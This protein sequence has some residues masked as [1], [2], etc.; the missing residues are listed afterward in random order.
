MGC[1]SD[2]RKD[3]PR[4]QWASAGDIARLRLLAADSTPSWQETDVEAPQRPDAKPLYLYGA[5]E[6]PAVR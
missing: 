1:R 2:P 6:K 3:F 4:G 5:G